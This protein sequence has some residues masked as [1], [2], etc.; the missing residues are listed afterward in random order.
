M[1]INSDKIST[2]RSIN[3]HIAGT[4]FKAAKEVAGW[5]GAL[6]AQDYGMSKCALGIRLQN[7]T[8]SAINNEIDSGDSLCKRW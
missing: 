3:Q 7:T 8:E 2:L 4:K 6:Q 5:M 1:A